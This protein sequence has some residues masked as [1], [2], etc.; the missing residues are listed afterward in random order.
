MIGKKHHHVKTLFKGKGCGKCLES[1]YKGRIVIAEILPFDRD[2]DEL[3]AAGASR[4]EMYEYILSKG[5]I[6][7]IEDGIDKVIQGVTD[8]KELMRV[9][10]MTDRIEVE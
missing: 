2:F 6:P 3:V 9:V 5:F 1:G 8:V 10:D 4:K 7:M